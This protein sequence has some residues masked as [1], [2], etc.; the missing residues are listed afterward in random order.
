MPRGGMKR[1]IPKRGREVSTWNSPTL[2]PAMEG[3][4]F[5]HGWV[6]LGTREGLDARPV[7][8]DVWPRE[9]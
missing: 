3:G 9:G 1:G 4:R 5:P 7:E 6:S 8:P 2:Q